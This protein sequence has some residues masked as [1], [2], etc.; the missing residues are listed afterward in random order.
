MYPKLYQFLKMEKIIILFSIFEGAK[1]FMIE[2]FVYL[3]FLLFHSFIPSVT[4]QRL[5][6]ALHPVSHLTRQECWN[7]RHAGVVEGS[8][9]TIGFTGIMFRFR[10]TGINYIIE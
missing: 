6:Y 4:T 8:P 9:R 2:N 5:H 10:R 3:Y 1:I 7:C